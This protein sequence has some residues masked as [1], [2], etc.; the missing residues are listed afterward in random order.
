MPAVVTF[1]GYHDSGKTTLVSQVVK[2]LKTR[3]HR[4][5]VMKSSNETGVT[6][7]STGTDTSA[8]RLAGADSVLFVAPDQMVLQTG[9]SDQ[10]VVTL[11]H[12]YFADADIVIGEGFKHARKIAKI[13]VRRDSDQDLRR[14]VHGVIAIATDLD[15]AGDYV[16]SLREANEIAQFIEKRFIQQRDQRPEKVF[17]LVNGRKIPMKEFIQDCLAGT[18][19]GFVDSLKLTD[20]ARE[21]EMRIKLDDDDRS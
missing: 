7:D 12:R 19:I 1:I 16:F 18:V 5:A 6:F 8:H 15:I 4:V 17:L 9:P 13:E 21:I 3:G 14:E 11:A 2:H 10:S 20:G